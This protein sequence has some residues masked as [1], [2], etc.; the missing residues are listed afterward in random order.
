LSQWR[1]GGQTSFDLV[2]EFMQELTHGTASESWQRSV[3]L[4]MAARVDPD[5]EPRVKLGAKD[6]P[7]TAAH[8]F[9][10]AGYLLVDT[11]ATT[12][13]N[14][15]APTP[16]P[17]AEQPAAE[18]ANANADGANPA[19]RDGSGRPAVD[20]FAEPQPAA[21]FAEP[22]APAADAAPTTGKAKGGKKKP[23]PKAKTPKPRTAKKPA[24]SKPVPA[25][26]AS[27]DGS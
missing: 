13:V 4:V 22:P 16:R 7:P 1:T 17:A 14:R 6:E 12:E 23:P 21:G 20:G 3:E 8:P 19:L 5:R 11:G 15:V 10:W 25:A 2:R 24:K 18:A 26:D 9:F 27:E